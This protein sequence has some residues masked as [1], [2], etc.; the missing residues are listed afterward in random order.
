MARIQGLKNL[1]QNLNKLAKKNKA[2]MAR[3]LKKAGLLIQ[4]ESLAL[5]P[6]D[7]GNLRAS[8][9]VRA[10]QFGS[11]FVVR[12]GYTASY[13]IYVHEV[14]PTPTG[15]SKVYATHGAAYNIKHAEDIRKKRKYW[16]NGVQRTYSK[17]GPKQQWKYLEQPFREH[18][19]DA[20]QMVREELES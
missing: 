17:R 2:G 19:K 14:P 1:H 16:Y 4:R 5:V 20:I 15:E 10:E 6:V 7:L 18:R 12:I 9:F 3:G 8:S 11:F 13:A